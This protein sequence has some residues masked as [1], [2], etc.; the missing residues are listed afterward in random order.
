MFEMLFGNRTDLQAARKLVEAGATLLDVRTPEEFASGH[1]AGAVN[2]PVQVLDA[3]RHELNPAHPV[4]VYC[5]SGGRSASAATVLRR[6][7]FQH[8]VDV[9]PMPRW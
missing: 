5:R 4:V 3:R 1:V 9:G 2:I 7:G 6:A 8:V